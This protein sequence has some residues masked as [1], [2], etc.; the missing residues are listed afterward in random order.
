M[1]FALELM[2]RFTME[3]LREANYY[4]NISGCPY[5][6]DFDISLAVSLRC[7]LNDTK[8]RLFYF[9]SKVN[10]AGQANGKFSLNVFNHR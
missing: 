3:R 10:E 2:N 5:R 7:V 9:F 6:F 4:Y 8:S 1:N